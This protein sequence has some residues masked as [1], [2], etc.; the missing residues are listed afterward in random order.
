M[1]F[2]SNKENDFNEARTSGFS[3]AE[4]TV[5]IVILL[6]ISAIALPIIFNQKQNSSIAVARNDAQSVA[7]AIDQ[8][9]GELSSVVPT[10]ATIT[11]A[12]NLITLTTSDTPA[13][14]AT[15]PVAISNGSALDYSSPNNNT[16][17]STSVY[18]IA[19]TFN[20][21]TVYQNGGGSLP[22]C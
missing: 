18:C 22:N 10:G 7:S 6:I 4:M 9:M 16:A 11:Y 20:G 17:T 2:C 21:Y 14:V 19:L 1:N 3:L 13:V 12:N 5:A 15:S 8:A